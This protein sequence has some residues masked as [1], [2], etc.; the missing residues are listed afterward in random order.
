MP[1][2]KRTSE[3]VILIASFFIAFAV[4]LVAKQRDFDNQ[5]VAA[6]VVGVG[7]PPNIETRIAPPALNV[8]VQYPKTFAHLIRPEAFTIALDLK[9]I[10]ENFAGVDK[11]KSIPFPISVKNV[12]KHNLPDAVRPNAVLGQ[13]YV[14]LSARLYTQKAKIFVE[15]S[16]K[17]PPDYRL[18]QDPPTVEPAEVLL[19][20]SPENLKR[21]VKQEKNHIILETQPVNIEGKKGNFFEMVNVPLPVGL[22]PVGKDTLRVRVH[23]VIG[24]QVKR[25]TFANVPIIIKTFSENLKPVYSPTAAIVTVEAPIS[26]LKKLNRDSFIFIPRQPLEET[27][28]YTANIAI[29]VKFSDKTPPLIREKATI[30][31]Y[32]PEVIRIKIVPRLEK[33]KKATKSPTPVP[34]HRWHAHRWRAFGLRHHLAQKEGNLLWRS[35]V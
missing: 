19:T 11:F 33:S 27:A 21:A 23:I 2:L 9:G 18:I 22:K 28:G 12:R 34:T 5:I 4:W 7:A 25:K 13:D 24:E 35:C 1:R 16:G 17:P 3:I 26:M 31:S 29:D 30:V 32:K 6:R 20:G 15:K 8:S 14:T 10:N